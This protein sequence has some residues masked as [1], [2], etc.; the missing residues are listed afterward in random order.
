MFDGFI[1]Y[2][3]LNTSA[4]TNSLFLYLDDG[5]QTGGM[6]LTRFY[7]LILVGVVPPLQTN[8]PSISS[9]TTTNIGG[10]TNAFSLKWFASTNDAFEVQ[11]TTNLAPV[12]KWHTFPNIIS[13]D[14][15]GGFNLLDAS[16]ADSMKFYRLILL[17]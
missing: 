10:G 3:V 9:V 12:I 11:W 2:A 15:N 5:S 4:P 8:V 16:P 1:N 17:P 7:R 6:D 14:T 13:S